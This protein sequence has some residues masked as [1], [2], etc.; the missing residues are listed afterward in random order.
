MTQ[1]CWR[2]DLLTGECFCGKVGY[3]IDGDLNGMYYCHC[4][5]CRKLTG[6]SFAT[7]ASLDAGLFSIT[8]GEELVANVGHD[9]HHRFHCAEC[10]SWIYGDSTDYPG[11][12]F[13]PCGT[14]NEPPN[15]SP[16]HHVCVDSKAAWV[17]INDDLPQYPGMQPRQ[18]LEGVK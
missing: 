11:M 18:R 14:L 13:I 10:H 2:T 3:Q 8:R 1:P 5:R 6:S 4:S 17:R 15:Q 7:N 12:K 9:G 16:T